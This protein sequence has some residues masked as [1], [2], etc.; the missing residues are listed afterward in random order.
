MEFIGATGTGADVEEEEKAVE[1]V[2]I[3][4]FFADDAVENGLG[5]DEVGIVFAGVV[6][7]GAGAG[8]EVDEGK[9]D[10]FAPADDLVVIP[11]V[12]RNPV[13]DLLAGDSVLLEFFE[14]CLQ[15]G[16]K[17]IARNEGF[18]GPLPWAV[19]QM[20]VGMGT[21]VMARFTNPADEWSELGVIEK[22]AGEIERG[23]RVA[24]GQF[25]ENNR[26]AF[27][28]GAAGK[29]EGDFLL[30]GGAADDSVFR[31]LKTGD[32]GF[33]KGP[34]EGKESWE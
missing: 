15:I 17:F 12:G 28:K 24:G 18:F 2:R 27:G 7:V 14:I 9:A 3:L 31:V 32:G 26:A 4:F 10:L 5:G 11:F 13:E 8:G 1:T 16:D 19:E 23:F 33:G 25:I 6:G 20:L 29:L 34:G 21:D 22:P 30:V